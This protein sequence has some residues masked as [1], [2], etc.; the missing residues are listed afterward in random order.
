MDILNH[1]LENIKF[2]NKKT[3]NVQNTREYKPKFL[4]YFEIPVS[5]IEKI[6]DKREWKKLKKYEKISLIIKYFGNNSQKFI[7][8]EQIEKNLNDYHID[9]DI[10]EERI[11][12]ISKIL[13]MNE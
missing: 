8:I 6:K 7:L 12:N 2:K 1:L 5:N 3:R 4:R 13:S 9:Y 11:T 10:E